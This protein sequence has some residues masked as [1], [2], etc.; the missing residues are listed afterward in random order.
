MT[1]R[2]RD[3]RKGHHSY[4]YFTI[5]IIWVTENVPESRVAL[6]IWS[7]LFVRVRFYSR[8]DRSKHAAEVLI[9]AEDDNRGLRVTPREVAQKLLG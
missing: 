2:W 6:N 8:F 1:G 3:H 4:Y 5:M 7:A 9:P